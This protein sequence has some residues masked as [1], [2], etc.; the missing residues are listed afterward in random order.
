MTHPAKI[1]ALLV[2]DVQQA[3]DDPSWGTRNN[4]QAENNIARLLQTWRRL[5][6]PI[7]HVQHLSDT[8]SSTLHPDASGVAFKP[9][10]QPLP[11]EPIIQKRVNSAFIG[12]HLEA[13]LHGQ[14]LGSLVIC[15]L[16]T[17]HC[18]STTTRMAA[19]LGF[20]AV[21][22]SDATATFGKVGPDGR[23][24]SAQ[25]LHDANLTSLDG[26]FALVVDT[27]TVLRDV[28][29]GKWS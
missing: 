3:F 24:Y 12:T 7:I 23:M 8:P 14:G 9:E 10:A 15:G 13:Y 5:N 2:I 17:D 20:R 26:E 18:V 11:G 19:N 22:V 4:L 28:A 16:T 1:P 29:D 21:L 6:A 25:E 27:Q